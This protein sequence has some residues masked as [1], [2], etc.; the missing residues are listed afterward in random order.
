MLFFI[1]KYQSIII[2]EVAAII[3]RYNAIESGVTKSKAI[4]TTINEKPQKKSSQKA[5]NK[6]VAYMTNKNI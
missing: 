3:N 5:K 4:S 1:L 6:L 2:I